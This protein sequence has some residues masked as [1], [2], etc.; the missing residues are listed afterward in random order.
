MGRHATGGRI[1]QETRA[2]PAVI[3]VGRFDHPMILARRA[4]SCPARGACGPQLS[5]LPPSNLATVAGYSTDST[6]A[7][8][9]IIPTNRVMDANAAASSTTA[10]IMMHSPC[11][12]HRGNIVHD[13][14][15][16][17][18]SWLTSARVAQQAKTH[19]APKDVRC[20]TM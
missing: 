6:C 18:A 8:T 19:G 5:H 12:E 7:H 3:C 17:N 2:L 13:M 20:A 1:G 10:R 11:L 15:R 14:F 9:T 16:V 4:L